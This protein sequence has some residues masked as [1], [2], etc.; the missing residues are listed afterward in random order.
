MP[1]KVHVTV[2]AI[3]GAIA[4][5]VS[6]CG[7][8]GDSSTGRTQGDATLAFAVQSAPNSLDPAQLHDGTQRYVWASLYD[9]LLYIDNDGEI[10]PS[11]AKSWEYSDD[12]RTLTLNLRDDLTF[13]D[14]DPVTSDAVKTTL[15]RTRDTPGPQQGNLSAIESVGTPD[16]HTAVLKLSQ[17]DPNLLVSLAYGSGVIGDPDTINDKRTALNPIGSG[18]YVLN[19]EETVDGSKYV[20]ERRDDYWNVDAYPLKTVTVKVIQDRTALFN[21]LLTG[22]LDAGT[23]DPT[24]AKQVSGSG[25]TLTKVDGVTVGGIVIADREGVV[26][27]PLADVRVRRAI[28]LAID[29]QGIVDAILRGQGQPTTQPFNPSSPAYQA[30]LNDDYPYDPG[31][32]RRLL[33]EAGYPNGFSITMPATVYVQPLQPTLTQALADVGIKV[34]WE[35]V[36]AQQ[37]GQTTRWGMYFNLGGVAPP[38]RTTELYFSESGSQNPF[39]TRDPEL[40]ALLR[41]LAPETDLDK[42][43]Q[44]YREINDFA[45]KDAWLAP[46]FLQSTTWATA[47]GIK[48]VGGPESLNDIRVFGVG[49]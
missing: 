48:Y 30:D 29:R 38:S 31:K 7:T 13:S 46:F 49:D 1:G 14:G 11:A 21:A 40:D 20:L 27:P 44:L 24:Q 2:G 6:G 26:A 12:A 41:K 22:E 33:A 28:N 17:P 32:A 36:P 5:T 34:D 25:F 10:Q 45:V 18:P 9:T 39:G 37:S 43:N 42:A 15:E 35:P 47:S 4:L 16:E 3:A 19:R 8:A 23:V